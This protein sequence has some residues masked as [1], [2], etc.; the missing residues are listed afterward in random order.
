MDENLQ[1][2]SELLAECAG[3]KGTSAFETLYKRYEGF[4]YS[5]C[6]RYL[7]NPQDAEDATM[8]CFIV[9]HDKANTIQDG[10]KLVT[11]LHSCAVRV[12]WNTAKTRQHR[13]EREQEA[14]N[15]QLIEGNE[16]SAGQWKAIL[17]R[18]D[19]EI[20][21]LPADQQSV[22]VLHFYKGQSRSQMAKTLG[23]PEGT[24]AARLNRAIRKLQKRFARFA[25]S[26]KEDAIVNNISAT[27]LAVPVPVALSAKLAA[28]AK[29][30]AVGGAVVEIVRATLRSM[31]WTQVKAA[32]LVVGGIALVPMAIT[33]VVVL[34]PVNLNNAPAQ[35]D[36]SANEAAAIVPA[37]VNGS[38]VTGCTKYVDGPVLW[39]ED[40]EE[41]R[42]SWKVWGDTK[43]LGAED[44]DA[45]KR[46]A[47]AEKC[48]ER[49]KVMRDGKETWVG[50]VRGILFKGEKREAGI[51][52]QFLNTDAV[53]CEFDRYVFPIPGFA[54]PRGTPFCRWMRVRN[55]FICVGDGEQARW[56]HRYFVDGRLVTSRDVGV[57]GDMCL[58]S[59]D[60]QEQI[61]YDN[62]VVR[63]LVAVPAGEG[64]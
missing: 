9:L 29:G 62:I 37:S 15:M 34:G 39:S 61:Y 52:L 24:I 45:M 27:A 22:L 57:L 44:Q 17:P 7:R 43:G 5:V 63:Q 38:A 53:S 41:G 11:W 18:L 48:V 2:D 20:A 64:K 21:G 31:F 26:L 23:C 56:R 54:L 14:Y 32:A 49:K 42:G 55:E 10:S 40:F 1:S 36:L 6:L 59:P 19:A 4:V 60:P 33:A 25:P 16:D 12:A 30:E 47:Q 3:G 46:K 35:P 58:S 28:M 51:Q 8:A 50:S 13:V